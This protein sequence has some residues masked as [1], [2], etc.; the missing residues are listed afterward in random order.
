MQWSALVT[1]GI[2]LAVFGYVGWLFITSEETPRG[3]MAF[4][5]NQCAKVTPG[6][7][8]VTGSTHGLVHRAA[9]TDPCLINPDKPG[10]LVGHR[11]P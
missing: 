3:K 7:P 5:P 1:L 2:V 6:D 11:R 9:T 10:K 8:D 4:K